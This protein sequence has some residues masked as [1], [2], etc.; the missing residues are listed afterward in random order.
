LRPG[1]TIVEIVPADEAMTMQVRLDPRDIDVVAPGQA[2][3]VSLLSYP[4]RNLRKLYGRVN[5]VSADI[6]VDPDTGDTYY[7]AA[8]TVDEAALAELADGIVLVPG[9]PVEVQISV[10]SRT[11]LD[12]L[13][14]PLLTFRDR[15]L[16]ET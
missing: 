2:A 11:F 8:I 4:Q 7:L 6:L 10:A 5:N 12:Y 3:T 14:E 15:A 16:K 13:I 1:E 9:M